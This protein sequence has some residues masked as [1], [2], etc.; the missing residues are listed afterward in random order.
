MLEILTRITE[1]YGEDG[2]IEKL[3]RLATTIGQT[4]LC[5]LGQAAPNPVVSTIKHFREEYEAHIYNK[6]CPAGACKA[7]LR[8]EIDPEKCVGCTACARVC[9]VDCIEGE[10]KKT[11]R[12]DQSLC[13]RCGNCYEACK[14]DAVL[15]K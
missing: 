12:I 7:L 13:I 2:D 6:A 10:R 3:E 8:F 9:P 5:G 1:G 14:F 4:S 11:H 15:R